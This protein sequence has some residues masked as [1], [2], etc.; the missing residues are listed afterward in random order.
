MYHRQCDAYQQRGHQLRLRRQAG[1]GF[2]RRLDDHPLFQPLRLC[3]A[4]KIRQTPVHHQPAHAG[5]RH[6]RRHVGP[7]GPA[8]D[9]ARADY[10]AAVGIFQAHHDHLHGVHPQRPRRPAQ[11]VAPGPAHRPLCRDSVPAGL[12]TA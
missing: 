9:P 2:R 1:G 11:Y 3:E 12:E 4:E 5:R 7:G 8:L 10:P 6:V